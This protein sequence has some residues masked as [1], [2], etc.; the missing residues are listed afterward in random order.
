MA[1]TANTCGAEIIDGRAMA[2]ALRK[3]TSEK[4]DELAKRLGRRPC[5]AVVRE[6]S[7]RAL[8]MSQY[9]IL[10]DSGK[11]ADDLLVPGHCGR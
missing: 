7:L 1:G 10:C 3:E 5:L 9:T 8:N 6:Q 2:A 4:V 11:R